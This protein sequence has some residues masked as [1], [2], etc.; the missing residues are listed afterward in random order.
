MFRQGEVITAVG[1]PALSGDNA[2]W[3]VRIVGSDGSEYFAPNVE[4]AN[5]I[6][7]ERRERARRAREQQ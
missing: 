6:E 7:A 2:M 4:D 1:N 3:M 5:A